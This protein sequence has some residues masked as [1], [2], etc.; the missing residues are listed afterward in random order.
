MAST[1]NLGYCLWQDG[2][3]FN[4]VLGRNL[5][6]SAQTATG[7]VAT[8]LITLGGVLGSVG[9]M[10]VVPTSGMTIRVNAGFCIVPNSTAN[11]QGAYRVGTMVSNNLT[12]ATADPTNPRIDLVC[13][14]VSDPGTS[15]GFS[16]LQ[17]IAGTPAGSPVAP[18]LPAN[19]I[20][21]ANVAVA[22]N[23]SSISS[24][25]IT[26][27]RQIT[28]LGGGQQVWP[29]VA[30]SG[31]GF[32]GLINY[33]TANDRFFHNNSAVSGVGE[34]MKTL[35]WSPVK[36]TNGAN[37]SLSTSRT[38][39]KTVNFTADGVTDVKLTFC[40]PG[41]F[42]TTMGLCLISFGFYIDSTN[43]Q[44]YLV[45][46]RTD[47]S[48][49]GV[50]YGGQT[51]EYT[52]SSNTADTPTAGSH[53]FNLGVLYTSYASGTAPNLYGAGGNIWY[54]RAEPVNQ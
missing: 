47:A 38:T 23:A 48:F 54:I 6:V 7:G 37:V 4:G 17:I 36:A 14:T 9:A 10:Q 27:K 31:P 53:A 24:G 39:I 20:A 42:Q 13:V 2:S 8:S 44:S 26:D 19:S 34:P 49:A 40:F 25:N 28:S 45:P 52:T 32:N 41:I 3:T 51:L 43:V 5:D 33:D 11:T 16:E 29:T 50:A 21:L 15:A 35:P 30:S 22:A 18:S 46:T 12:V 1:V